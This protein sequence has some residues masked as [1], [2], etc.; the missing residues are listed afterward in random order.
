LFCFAIGSSQQRSDLASAGSSG[1]PILM[2]PI[3]AANEEKKCSD[4]I[5]ISPLRQLPSIV[6][7]TSRHHVLQIDRLKRSW[8][9]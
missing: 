1:K 7:A 3:L 6:S 5:L 4:G 8:Q 2:L 9:I